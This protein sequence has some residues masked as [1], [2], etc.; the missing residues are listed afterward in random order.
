MWRWGGEH[1]F[2]VRILSS[3]GTP[4]WSSGNIKVNLPATGDFSLTLEPTGV[5]WFND[6]PKLEVTVDG[7][8]LSP[9]DS[10]SSSPYAL[11]AQ[12]V[13]D[14]AVTNAQIDSGA[15]ID[16]S[17][18]AISGSVTLADWRSS[19]D[20]AKIDANVI[21]GTVP[22]STSQIPGT[23]L[24]QNTDETQTIEPTDTIVPLKIKPKTGASDTIDIVQFQTADS[25]K[26]AKVTGKA[27]LQDAAGFVTPVGAILPYG[28]SSIP[29][30]WLLCDGS[31]VSRT[32]YDELFAVVGTSFG[33]GNGSSTFN[34]PDLR[35]IFPKG[36]G[37]TNRAA[38]VDA[39]GNY[40]AGTLG[41]YS[42]DS[43]Q[44]HKHA[45]DPPSTTSGG[46]SVNHSHGL[47][48]GSF[49]VFGTGG[50]GYASG[51]SYYLNANAN[52]AVQ[53]VDHTHNTDIVSFDSA[54]PKTDGTNGNPRLATVTEPPSLGINYII[55]H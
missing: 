48:S 54:V 15:G 4:L 23:A 25:A 42:Q 44:G 7:E 37:T 18:I 29:T 31:E 41:G 27:R 28:G 16:P 6:N 50:S 40:Y 14:G 36:A 21:Q 30:G 22:V 35:G 2:V 49:V 33:N 43:I 55:K 20:T 8:L 3:D 45:V 52:T 34:L 51:T 19:T 13:A 10:F 17:K 39:A 12:T 46:I 26:T 47:P 24:V 38:G 5:D 9:T 1:I 32:T 53:S 11:A